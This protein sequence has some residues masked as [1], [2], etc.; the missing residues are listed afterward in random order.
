[1]SERRIGKDVEESGGGLLEIHP[2]ICL[3]DLRKSRKKPQPVSWPRFEPG[4]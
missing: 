1:M 3:E 2:G 4:T